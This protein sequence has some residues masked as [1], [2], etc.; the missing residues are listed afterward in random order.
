MRHWFQIYLA[1]SVDQNF[2]NLLIDL[3][4]RELEPLLKLLRHKLTTTSPFFQALSYE[5][6]SEAIILGVI[7]LHLIVISIENNTHLD[8]LYVFLVDCIFTDR[9]SLDAEVLF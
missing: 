7:L 8:G 1:L 9:E 3:I 4:N 6:V 2:R 5:V